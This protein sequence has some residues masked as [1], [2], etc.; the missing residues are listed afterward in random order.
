MTTTTRATNA[1]RDAK[2]QSDARE[3]GGD[4]ERNI[5]RDIALFE[6]W[7][8]GN[9]VALKRDFDNG[10][11]LLGV[12]R[13]E[14]VARPTNAFCGRV[15]RR[16]DRWL[17]CEAA[18]VAKDAALIDAFFTGASARLFRP[19]RKRRQRTAH[20]TNHGLSDNRGK[21]K[22]DEKKKKRSHQ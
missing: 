9:I 11:I 5:S 18:I 16:K 8:I 13:T 12:G 2:R 6:A 15:A 19:A 14:Q 1:K 17:R 4:Q 22:S 21:E 3:N 20:S 7:Q 10:E